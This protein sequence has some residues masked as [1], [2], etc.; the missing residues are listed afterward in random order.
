MSTRRFLPTV[1]FWIAAAA[2]TGVPAQQAYDWML[3]AGFPSPIV[4]ADNPMSRAKVELGRHLFYDV[5]LSAN[6]TQSCAS[7]HEQAK[8]FTDGRARSVGST[9]QQHPRGSMSLVNV[10]Y[11]AALTWGNPTVTRLEDQA[12]VPMY[13]VAPIELGLDRSDR[14][15]EPVRRDPTY[16]RLLAEA[17]Q[18]PADAITRDHVVKSIAAFERAIVS[19]RSPYDRYHFDRDDNAIS[20]AAKRGEIL[21]HS[22]PQSCFTCHGGIHFSGAMGAGTRS[23][24][25]EFHNTG[26]YNLPGLMSY[27]PDN[28]GVYQVTRARADVGKFKAPTLRNVAVTAPYMHDGSVATLEEAIDHYAAGGRTLTEGPNKGVGRDNPNKS[29]SVRGFTISPD[30]R[31]DLVAFLQSLTDEALLTDPRFANPWTE[32]RVF[33]RSRPAVQQAFRPA[34]QGAGR[35]E[36]LHDTSDTAGRPSTSR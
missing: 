22:R 36:G 13:G 10:A 24:A 9:G 8:A 16:Q 17:F 5:R 3:P 29:V 27:P 6:G 31:A 20:D 2:W 7:C 30:Q 12:L 28:A 19:A 4:P 21:F 32:T 33:R 14:W 18:T 34:F 35:P 25:V 1:L 11:A 23:T 26:L 15:L